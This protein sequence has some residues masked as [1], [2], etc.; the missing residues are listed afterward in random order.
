MVQEFQLKS[1]TVPQA[2]KKLTAST[3][4]VGGTLAAYTAT[5]AALRAGEKVCWV[6]PK[7]PA[8][9]LRVDNQWLELAANSLAARRG[10]HHQLPGTH[11][12]MS[13]SQRQWRESVQSAQAALSQPAMGGAVGKATAPPGAAPAI[14]GIQT[15]LQNQRLI[16]VP[17]ARPLWV[18]YKENRGQ[19]RITQVVFRLLSK[20]Q[21]FFVQAE[22][23]IDATQDGDLNR[24]VQQKAGVPAVEIP[25]ALTTQDLLPTRPRQARGRCFDDSVGLGTGVARKIPLWIRQAEQVPPSL[26]FT[27]P[28]AAL[29][30]T[31][32]EGLLIAGPMAAGLA[33]IAPLAQAPTVA[34]ALGE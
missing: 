9:V 30:S 19:R 20:P 7:P 23:A 17:D 13:L 29:I 34:W 10:H 2:E 33:A 16:V 6:T 5:L 3:L 15:Y 25:M 26:P 12:A 14:K 4:V 24:L 31:H 21:R 8:A 27:L 32:T 18:L 11:F 28:G 1:L 22:V